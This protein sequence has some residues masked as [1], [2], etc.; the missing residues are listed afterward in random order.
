MAERANVDDTILRYADSMSPGEISQMLGGVISPATVAARTQTLLQAKDWLTE[1]Q[2]DQLV[3]LRMKQLV[4]DLLDSKYA[5]DYKYMDIRL[6]ALTA[7]GDRL[8]KRRSATAIDL[9]TL[10]GNQGALLGR[11]VDMALSYMKGALR[12]AVDG[13]KWDELVRE[14]V[15]QAQMEIRKH[16]AVEA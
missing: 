4:N 12:E 10:Y 14:A 16:E 11:V 8:D 3:T 1:T 2:E 13:E 7:L 5:Q 9:N 6:K 15:V